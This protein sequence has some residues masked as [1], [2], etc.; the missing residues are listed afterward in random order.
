VSGRDPFAKFRAQL[1]D[2][3][4]RP[5]SVLGQ[6]FL[7]DPSL[8]RVIAEAAAPGPDDLVLEIGVGLGFLTRE[9]VQRARHVIGVEIDARLLQV[10]AAELSGCSN[11]A[12]LHADVLGGEGATLHPRVLAALHAAAGARPFLVVANLPYATSG[13]LLA[14]LCQGPELPLRVVVLLQRELAQRLAA[15]PGSKEYGSLAALVQSLFTV[16]L[17][18]EVSPQVF[19]PRPKVVSALL[20]LDLRADTA[21]RGLSAAKAR[22]SLAV[23]LRV[24]FQ[25]RRK[26]L[27]VTL[28]AAILAIGG[29]DAALPA[30]AGRRAEALSPAELLALWQGCAKDLATPPGAP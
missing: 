24:L 28:P 12:L 13:P 11:L 6:N 29:R 10:A 3:G 20:R 2:L 7:L 30:A 21:A 19:R 15:A 23:F 8:H 17:L 14:A 22:S 25:Q 26:T 27:R 16:R 5:S 4:F 18:R 1:A 9:L